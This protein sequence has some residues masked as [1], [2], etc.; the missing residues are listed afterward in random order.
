M[1]YC[2]VLILV[3]VGGKFVYERLSKDSFV[4]VDPASSHSKR[5]EHS[6]S[7]PSGKAGLGRQ[8]IDEEDSYH[9]NKTPYEED[10]DIS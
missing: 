5:N 10:N 9:I 6:S 8:K 1:Q 2:I 3:F 7:T 4:P